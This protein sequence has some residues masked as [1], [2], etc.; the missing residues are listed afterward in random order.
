MGKQYRLTEF[1]LICYKWDV[2]PIIGNH[3]YLSLKDLGDVEC[4]IEKY[5]GFLDDIRLYGIKHDEFR[6]GSY[7]LSSE[8]YKKIFIDDAILSD[9]LKK[10]RRFYKTLKRGDV[11]E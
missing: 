8:E 7:D 9:H 4:V 3:L 10:N 5:K 2:D 1:G 6:E 11:N